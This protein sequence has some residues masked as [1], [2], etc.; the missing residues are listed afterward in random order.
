MDWILC[1]KA[2]LSGFVFCVVAMSER[3]SFNCRYEREL[4]D[5]REKTNLK[6][7]A[8]D[9]NKTTTTSQPPPSTTTTQARTHVYNYYK[10]VSRRRHQYGDSKAMS[11]T[12]TDHMG[13]IPAYKAGVDAI[14]SDASAS[15]DCDTQECQAQKGIKGKIKQQQLPPLATCAANASRG[16]KDTRGL[17][18]RE[19]SGGDGQREDDSNISRAHEHDPYQVGI[20]CLFSKGLRFCNSSVVGIRNRLLYSVPIDFARK[21]AHIKKVVHTLLTDFDGL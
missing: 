2:K 10:R 9:I 18:S 12:P 6:R 17:T 8:T 21:Q 16:A 1:T 4:T 3:Q 20:Q 19:S 13:A 11:F 7:P 5:A 15:V 14:A